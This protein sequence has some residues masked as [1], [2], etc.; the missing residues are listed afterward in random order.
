MNTL[1]ISARDLV[2]R[3][4]GDTPVEEDVLHDAVVEMMRRGWIPSFI[5]RPFEYDRT[6][7][8]LPQRSPFAAIIR[9]LDGGGAAVVPRGLLE[10]RTTFPIACIGSGLVLSSLGVAIVRADGNN[11]FIRATTPA[12]AL[13]AHST[14]IHP[15]EGMETSHLIKVATGKHIPQPL[16]NDNLLLRVAMAFDEFQVDVPGVLNAASE[17]DVISRWQFPVSP[18]PVADFDVPF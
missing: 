4:Y 14:R 9:C 16:W 13:M 6:I 3:F 15:L 5:P 17:S 18:G 12:L 2:S 10:S 8:F 1:K 7:V 11:V